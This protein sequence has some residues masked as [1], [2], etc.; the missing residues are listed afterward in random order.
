M[1]EEMQEKVQLAIAR[2]E[3]LLKLMTT[4]PEQA[5]AQSIS[6]HDYDR[7]PGELKPHFE[8]PFNEVGHLHVLPVC[9]GDSD[10]EPLRSLEISGRTYEVTVTGRRLRQTSK[11]N[12][13]L[14]GFTLEGKAV[15]KEE[16]LEA[17]SKEDADHLAELPSGQADPDLD[18]ATGAS[19]GPDHLIALAAGKRYHF[20]D[21]SSLAEFNRR[22]GE[23]DLTPGPHGGATVILAKGI[24]DTNDHGG[25][26]WDAAAKWTRDE[27]S[28]W[29]ETP[30]NVFFIRV[31]FPNLPGD[32]SS[33]ADLQSTLNGPV[34]DSIAEMSYGKTKIIA[35]VSAMTVRLPQTT[36]YYR[37]GEKNAELHSDAR[38]AY[39]AIA[40]ATSLSGYDIIG[41]HF[42]SISMS[43]GN[44]TY[45]GLASTGGSQQWIQGSAS[46]ATLIHEF[47]HNYGIL[48]ASFWKTTDGSVVGTGTSEEYGDTFDL[49]G[50][51]PNRAHHFGPRG[52]HALNW[53]SSS[54]VNALSSAGHSG[55]YRIHRFDHPDTT[56]EKRALRIAKGPGSDF[57]WV[58]YRPGVP[59]NP[60]LQSGAFLT[61]EKPGTSKTWLLDATPGT[62]M[63][64][65][66]GAIPLGST[67][68]DPAGQ[69]HITPL[70]RG[71]TPADA[72]AWLDINVQIGNFTNNR[73]PAV[74][75]TAPATGA[76]RVP[77]T[78]SASATD[79]DGDVLSY[80]WNFGDGSPSVSSNS[81]SHTWVMGGTYTVKVTANDMKGRTASAQA[82]ITIS[83]PLTNWS[84]R[85]TPENFNVIHY[86]EGRFVA[87]GTSGFYYSAD[88]INWSTTQS[89]PPGFQSIILVHDGEMFVAMVNGFN[90]CTPYVSEDGK[91]WRSGAPM[92]T[93]QSLATGPG[94][95]IAFTS[96]GQS[97]RSTDH[98]R[99][100]VNTPLQSS[101][102][103]SYAV[104]GNGVWVFVGPA[105]HA[106][107]GKV[108]TS[109]DGISW[110][111]QVG[112][113]TLPTNSYIHTLK[114]IDGAFYTAG[115]RTGIYRS[116]DGVTWNKMSIIGQEDYTIEAIFEGPDFMIAS[117]SRASDRV[118][119]ISFD[120]ESWYPGP[121]P[122]QNYPYFA[123]GRFIAGGSGFHFTPSFDLENRP[124][125][126]TISGP[127]T[128]ESRAVATFR[129]T[130]SDP[131]GDN[132]TL[133]WDFNDGSPLEESSN[134][135]HRFVAGGTYQVRLHAIDR[136]GGIATASMTV[137]V[138]DPLTE[139]TQ[140]NSGTTGHLETITAGNGKLVTLGYPAGVYRVSSDGE[141]W[142]G[143]NLGGNV[144]FGQV[145]HD[146]SQ[147]IACGADHDG[148]WK[149]TIY[150]SPDGLAWTRRYFAGQSLGEIS[151][152]AGR[153]VAVGGE[154]G[155][156]LTSED[157]ITWSQIPSGTSGYLVSTD[158]GDGQFVAGGF[159]PEKLTLTSPD[160]LVW[161]N[162]SS[163]IP[164]GGTS[165]RLIR[166]SHDR[167]LATGES[168]ELLYSLDKGASFQSNGHR[169]WN[170]VDFCYAGGFHFACG[171]L[172]SNSSTRVNLVSLDG[173]SWSPLPT[174]QEQ[175][176]RT[177]A[178][179]FNGR[180]YTSG[181][182]GSIWRSGVV[183]PAAA[184]GYAGWRQS[185]FPGT[186]P[187]SAPEEDFDGDGMPNIAEYATGTDPKNGADRVSFAGRMSAD[188]F[189]L[190]IPKAAGADD[191]TFAVQYSP[192]LDE[193]SSNGITVIED[194][195][196]R[197]VVSIP[198]GSSRGF[199]R[200]SFALD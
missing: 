106:S 163:G 9:S 25:F 50:S 166:H 12:T 124:P 146:G 130:A 78:F 182:N 154:P 61:W 34:S 150:T 132:L 114:F 134:C 10:L 69:L 29:T 81:V 79:P 14:A 199:L 135:H 200:P 31:D 57:Y 99:T 88:G 165:I 101:Q 195:P 22:L 122:S 60:W 84:S 63:G 144:T 109:P 5:L 87:A 39:Q 48:H 2:K 59:G 158:Y 141:T 23:L 4:D 118:Y 90:S 76:A 180:F 136:R 164:S 121:A 55:I 107:A 92:S 7:L 147:F 112:A 188:R 178:T 140:V 175:P 17:L 138:S 82:I 110:T 168:V 83:D 190:E 185:K 151:H 19:L 148:A 139:W 197:L 125:V 30:K 100:W 117:G 161:T 8:K 159:Q 102:V 6:Y 184:P 160:G 162:T 181:G 172:R 191:V 65:T 56:G 95:L 128:C 129:A 21:T 194:T 45:S 177:E 120:G 70:A 86:H 89:Y 58:G 93:V 3:R 53:I 15:L 115:T 36:S 72:D 143:G 28:S 183:T 73:A 104:F 44:V 119:L 32:P 94:V 85:P 40:G 18:F 16:T 145:I 113:L 77:I 142:T 68:S 66:D 187:L 43:S 192:D 196:T 27:A 152:G 116:L 103:V 71:G 133:L 126:A 105:F 75:L 51:G 174:P 198:L 11:E 74:N 54:Q 91:I 156:M 64:K 186:D 189:I 153:Y 157:G 176:S 49:M 1:P 111:E 42:R 149:G 173:A 171:N 38:A 137:T 96:T 13:P 35:A 26:D 20:A 98:G 170:V 37:T 155:T 67:Y 47:G 41:V 108:C 127:S 97:M 52:K 33:Q 123:D 24:S 62:P 193:W 131:D 179:Y 169:A 80:S 46:T 167:F